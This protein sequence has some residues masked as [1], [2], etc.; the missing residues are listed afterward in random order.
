MFDGIM[1]D[2]LMLN[3]ECLMLNGRTKQL[4]TCKLEK[5]KDFHLFWKLFIQL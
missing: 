3:F 4:T 5:D 2:E 1:L